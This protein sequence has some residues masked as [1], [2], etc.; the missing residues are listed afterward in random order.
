MGGRLPLLPVEGLRPD[1]AH[2]HRRLTATRAAA[3]KA[4]GYAAA[5]PDGRLIGPFNAFLRAPALAGAQLDWTQ[6]IAD[7]ALPPRVR[8]ATILTVGAQWAADYILYAHSRAAQS[9][10]LASDAITAL[11]EGRTPRGVDPAVLS[12][13]RLALGLVRDHLVPDDVYAD[14]VAAFGEEGLVALLALI[15]QYQATAAVLTCFQVPAPQD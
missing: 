2:L 8:E 1:Q 7:V 12:A 3:A 4:A 10:G 14:A 11:C 6:A 5:L 13:H 15:G 9:A